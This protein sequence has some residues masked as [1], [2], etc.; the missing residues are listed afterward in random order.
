[1]SQNLNHVRLVSLE[2]RTL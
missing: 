2:T 1:M